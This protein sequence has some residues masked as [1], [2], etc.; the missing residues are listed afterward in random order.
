MLLLILFHSP[1]SSCLAYVSFTSQLMPCL[2]FIHLTAHAL[3]MFH[4]PHSSCLAYVLFTSQLMPCLCFI[5]LTAHALP[6]FHSPHSSCL[7]YVSF[8][9]QLMPC[10]C[11]IH[12][13]AHERGRE[14]GRGN[15]IIPFIIEHN[16]NQFFWSMKTAV[17]KKH[18]TIILYNVIHT[19]IS[20]CS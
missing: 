4:S 13:T 1:H 19:Y 8:T 14:G 15:Y 6:M 12:L 17:M 7:A 11:F 20:P 10:L 16:Q 5:H 3:P 18:R 9:S 2:C